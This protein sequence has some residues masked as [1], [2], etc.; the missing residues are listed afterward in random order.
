M[1]SAPLGFP[2]EG[3]GAKDL[4]KAELEADKTKSLLPARLSQPVRE[5]ETTLHNALK[6]WDFISLPEEHLQARRASWRRIVSTFAHA[7]F[8]Y[9]ITCTNANFITPS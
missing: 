3:Q 4:G 1:C 9:L 5:V 6:I 2:S 7:S 8:L